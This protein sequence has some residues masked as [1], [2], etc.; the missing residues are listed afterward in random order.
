MLWA[1]GER[2]CLI[3]S[4]GDRWGEVRSRRSDRLSR[5]GFDFS[6]KIRVS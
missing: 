2:E 6:L 1:G 4:G 3:F 5:Q